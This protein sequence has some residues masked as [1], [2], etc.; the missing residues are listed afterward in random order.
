[1]RQV[2]ENIEAERVFEEMK[3]RGI[4][5]RQRLR[6]VFETVEDED[7][8]LARMAEAGG[9]FDFLKEEPDLYSDA[10]IKRRNV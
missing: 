9:A 5:P 4:Q 1:M 7:L 6:V 8:P 3:R 2:L 10:D